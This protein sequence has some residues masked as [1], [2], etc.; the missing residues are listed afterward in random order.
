M[1]KRN[2]L[3]I[4]LL[5][6]ALFSCKE[7]EVLPDGYDVPVV[8][9]K[10]VRITLNTIEVGDYLDV[11]SG[12]YGAASYVNQSNDKPYYFCN[13]VGNLTGFNRIGDCNN[14]TIELVSSELIYI[15]YKGNVTIEYLWL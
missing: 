12:N 14:N 7:D 6:I 11:S 9:T 10:H 8:V 15:D 13:L 2:I 4:A 3:I 5:G 1:I